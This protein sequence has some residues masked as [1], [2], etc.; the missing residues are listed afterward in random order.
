MTPCR[1]ST[2]TSSGGSSSSSAVA[3]AV[4][5]TVLQCPHLPHCS[6]AASDDSW[7]IEMKYA[8]ADPIDSYALLFLLL[9]HKQTE[10]KW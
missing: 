1:H 2:T 3:S 7:R 9:T 10:G 6:V 8:F 5:H 4:G